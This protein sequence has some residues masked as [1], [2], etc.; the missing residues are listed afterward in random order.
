MFTM[1]EVMKKKYHMFNHMH[2][3]IPM[4]HIY[5]YISYTHDY[6][7][8]LSGPCERKACFFSMESSLCP[9]D[10]VFGFYLH[11][12]GLYLLGMV[13]SEGSSSACHDLSKFGR[14]HTLRKVMAP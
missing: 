5:I 4:Y 9:C 11:I 2:N 7:Y 1:N 3:P 14:G 8:Y 12:L 13:A 6:T 10:I